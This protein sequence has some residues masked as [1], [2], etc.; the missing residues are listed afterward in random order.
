[1]P[2]LA[3]NIIDI[4]K[5]QQFDWEKMIRA[6]FDHKTEETDAQELLAGREAEENID[7]IDLFTEE[8][9]RPELESIAEKIRGNNR[10]IELVGRI[11]PHLRQRT[12]NW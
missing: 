2:E 6:S 4:I 1:M 12:E 3:Q 9:L 8:S 11:L 5:S 10:K 7:L